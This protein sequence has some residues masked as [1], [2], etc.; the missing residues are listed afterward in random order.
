MSKLMIVESPNKCKKIQSILGDGWIVKASMGHVRDLPPKEMG[1]DLQSFQP[2]YVPNDKGRK[3]LANLRK[4][5]KSAHEVWLATDPDREGEAIAWHLAQ[6]LHLKHPFR[7][8]FNAI[9]SKAVKEA[10][11][12]PGQLDMDL[13]RAQEGR[14]VLDRLVGY[15]VS[16][17]LTRACGNAVWLTAGRVQSVALRIV[18]ER[19]ME[20][21]QFRSI[22]YVEVFLIFD[23]EGITWEAKWLP[24]ELLSKNQQ[25]WTDREFAQRVAGLRDV[26][27]SEV[28]KEKKSRRPPAPFITSTLQQAASVTLRMSPRR[29]MQEAQSLFEAGLITYHRTDNPNLSDDGIREVVE[30]LR[31]NGHGDH[32]TDPANTWK[33]KEGAQEGHEAIRPTSIQSLPDKI[34]HQLPVD[35]YRLY[36]LIWLRSVACQMKPAVMNV[37]MVTLESAE[38]IDGQVMRFIAKGVELIYPGWRILSGCDTTSENDRGQDN[39]QLPVL[40][41]HQLLTASDGDV[42]DKKTK[43]PARYTEASLIKKL[44]SE[45]IG[46]PSTYASIIDNIISRGYVTVEKRKLVATELGQLIVKALVERFRFMELNYTRDIESQLDDIA[47][48]RNHYQHVVGTAY[49]E[50]SDEL[51]GLK[52]LSVE[53]TR[54]STYQCPECGQPLRLI[55]NKFWGCVSYPEC[56]FTA[57]NNKGKPGTKQANSRGNTIDKTYPC[58]CDKGYLQR[59]KSKARESYFWGCSRYPECKHTL[60]DNEGKPGEQRK[61]VKATEH[62]VGET[63]PECN[64]GTL[65]LRTMKKGKNEGRAFHGCTR[66]PVCRH[67]SWIQT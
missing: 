12:R 47:R 62:T 24:G 28:I 65:V 57:S 67:F 50:L 15:S 6:S 54:T 32:I 21:K 51:E 55:K 41:E 60:P 40:T 35:Q 16:P 33:A 27:V 22:D 36:Q 56:R 34:K 49:R 53:H 17:A 20:I 18:V 59:R 61:K 8:T 42:R 29:C 13:V 4:L 19:E 5:C 66:F 25:H 52:G 64:S 39:Q 58:V 23:Y 2:H 10:V 43:P 9:T 7:V 46:R 31:Q 30:W 48:G 26:S 63:C 1:V 44:E 45:G 14:R 11:S 38:Q 3:V 37:T